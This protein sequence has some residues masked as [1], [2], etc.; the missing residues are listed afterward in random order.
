MLIEIAQFEDSPLLNYY[1]YYSFLYLITDAFM[2]VNYYTITCRV[3]RLRLSNVVYK[4]SQ[5]K[6]PS[7][8]TFTKPM[9]P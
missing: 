1:L 2:S 5:I 3:I 6:A 8:V 7:Y 4:L 9:D